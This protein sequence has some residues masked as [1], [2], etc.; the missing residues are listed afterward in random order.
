VETVSCEQWY[1][2]DSKFEAS[3]VMDS[4][5]EMLAQALAKGY[6]GM[7]ALADAACIGE[8][9]WKA[10]SERDLRLTSASRTEALP[11]CTHSVDWGVGK[12]PIPV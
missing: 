3:K 7:R 1:L 12:P 11:T 9:N 2:E 6:A 8:E 10:F 5:N 4:W